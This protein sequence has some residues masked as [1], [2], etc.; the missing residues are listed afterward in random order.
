M[1]MIFIMTVLFTIPQSTYSINAEDTKG[2]VVQLHS[3]HKN[4]KLQK[5]S[6]QNASFAT[7]NTQSTK[8]K[9]IQHEEIVQL[10]EQFMDK[11]VQK[12]DDQN[13]VLDFNNK[14]QLVNSF[15]SITTTSLAKNYIDYYYKEYNDDLFIIP[16]E[17][18]P[19]FMK[20]QDYEKTVAENGQV[21]VKQQNKTELYGTYTVE[22]TFAQMDGKWKIVN[23]KHS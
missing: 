10:T 15:Q 17:T 5:K 18:P 4:G 9:D 22:F 6:K 2:K 19:W 8:G 13:R 16:T 23:I 20:D 12:T 11:L 7:T 14:R 21:H 1:T 3:A